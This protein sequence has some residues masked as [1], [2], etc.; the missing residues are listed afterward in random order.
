MER[1][2]QKIF[3][4]PSIVAI[5]YV[6]VVDNLGR[7]VEGVEK[8]IKKI[9]EV[10]VVKRKVKKIGDDLSLVEFTFLEDYGKEIKSPE[11]VESA[12]ALSDEGVR[13]KDMKE[14]LQ[15]LKELLA[16]I[17]ENLKKL[18]EEKLKKLEKL[19]REKN[20]LKREEIE[21]EIKELEEQIKNLSGEID[22]IA[23]SVK[24]LEQELTK[25]NNS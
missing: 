12:F 3:I 2:N 17:E 23:S 19:M 18:T 11:K 7:I 24:E 9:H 5:G 6:K 4:D 16:Y 15:G 22:K 20:S 1:K 13:I 14:K 25:K 8:N 10:E 21:R